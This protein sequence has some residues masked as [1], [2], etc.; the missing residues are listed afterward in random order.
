MLTTIVAEARRMVLLE[1]GP[2]ILNMNLT[3]IKIGP[4]AIIGIPGEPFT[5][6]GLE[7][8]ATEGFDMILP[9]CTAN[10]Y[11]GYFP[12]QSAFDEGG[13]EARVSNF[14]AG[15]AEHIIAEGTKLLE[16]Y[17]NN[18]S[19]KTLR[20][21]ISQFLHLRLSWQIRQVSISGIM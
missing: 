11:E 12:M 15:V 21:L 5:K 6:I 1:N 14:K 10:G 16:A 20:R 4:I 18:S 3:G 13:Y 2:D 9:C 19:Q 7:L 8:K 17:I